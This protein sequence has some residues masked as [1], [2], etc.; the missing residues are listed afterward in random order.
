M[1]WFTRMR[2]LLLRTS[3]ASNNP[4][5]TL[6][7]AFVR[8]ADLKAQLRHLQAAAATEAAQQLQEQLQA[9]KQQ[10]QLEEAQAAELQPELHSHLPGPPAPTLPTDQVEDNRQ[11]T[12]QPSSHQPQLRPDLSQHVYPSSPQLKSTQPPGAVAAAERAKPAVAAALDPV[13]LFRPHVERTSTPAPM[14]LLQIQAEQEAEAA[15]SA[16]GSSSHGRAPNRP[17]ANKPSTSAASSHRA[18]PRVLQVTPYLV[19]LI[20]FCTCLQHSCSTDCV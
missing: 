15:R 4:Y 3:A 1:D 20:V 8:L 16:V 13:S 9:Q 18:Q 14:G 2:M 10:A 17:N 11:T 19:L 6:H 12:H 7:H 5:L